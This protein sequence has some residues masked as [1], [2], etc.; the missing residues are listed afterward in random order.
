M[1]PTP[2]V[3]KAT[4]APIEIYGGSANDHAEGNDGDDSIFGEDGNDDLIGGS[5]KAGVAD[6]GE[7]LISGGEGQDVI[8]GDNAVMLAGGYVLGRT[9]T[10][11]D[12]PIGGG[13]IIEGDAD[14]DA[15]FG[16]VGNDVMWG[17]HGT[18]GP[19][20][21]AGAADYLEGDDGNDAIHGEAGTDDI[22][23][24]NS[25][26]DGSIVRRP[27]RH[28]PVRHRRDAARRRRRT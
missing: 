12:R 1:A 23:G 5:D 27:D 14:K 8:A 22:V 13:D 25:A 15:A 6:V 9:V 18:V 26:I 24:G 3:S 20:L 21:G 19:I 11:L 28:R 16:E 7:T 17:D 10:L 2:T 4:A